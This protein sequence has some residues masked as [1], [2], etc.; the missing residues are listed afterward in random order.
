MLQFAASIVCLSVLCLIAGCRERSSFMSGKKGDLVG[1]EFELILKEGNRTFSVSREIAK[2]QYEL[3]ENGKVI[4][5]DCAYH[6]IGTARLK[7]TDSSV[8]CLT[9]TSEDVILVNAQSA[10]SVNKVEFDRI[11]KKVKDEIRPVQK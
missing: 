1:A 3:L 2:E 8:D 4:S 10:I 11:L 6:M 9:L 7:Y 5:N